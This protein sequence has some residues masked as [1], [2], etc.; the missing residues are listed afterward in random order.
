MS[1]GVRIQLRIVGVSS[2]P[3]MVRNSPATSPKARSVW[4]ALR[5]LSWFL[6]PK[7]LEMTTPAPIARPLK[8]PTI[9]KMRLPEDATL[10]S[11]LDPRVLPTMS[12][13]AAL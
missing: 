3:K 13:S 4:M 12:E 5:S 9:M 1:A 8:N 2:T 10:A 7:Y 11:A 6:A